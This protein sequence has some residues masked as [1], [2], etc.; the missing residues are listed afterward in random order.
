MFITEKEHLRVKTEL[1]KR[2]EELHQKLLE[3]EKELGEARDMRGLLKAIIERTGLPP[4]EGKFSILTTN[5]YGGISL[6]NASVMLSDS[7]AQY[8]DDYYGGKVIKQEA[9]PVTILDSQGK[10]TYALTR[11][12]ADKGRNYLLVLDNFL[13]KEKIEL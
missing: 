7:V 4:M 13:S 9:T 11:R 8:V 10:A 5:G 2:N 6:S 1:E 3:R 12:P